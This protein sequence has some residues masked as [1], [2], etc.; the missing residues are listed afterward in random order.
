[1]RGSLIVQ[2][3]AVA[4][5]GVML[6][7]MLAGSASSTLPAVA[8]MPAKEDILGAYEKNGIDTKACRDRKPTWKDS[9]AGYPACLEPSMRDIARKLQEGST[10]RD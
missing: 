7:A 3:A 6:T 10:P 5:G 1:M 8:M 2:T 4:L 9:N